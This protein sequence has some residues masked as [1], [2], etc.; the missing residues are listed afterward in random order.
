MPIR[1][2]DRADSGSSRIPEAIQYG[3]K[4]LVT[5][6]VGIDLMEVP[7]CCHY[8]HYQHELIPRRPPRRWE[9]DGIGIHPR[10]CVGIMQEPVD[11]VLTVVPAIAYILE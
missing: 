5:Q 2:H 9:V 3:A 8:M 10:P 6:P 4:C 1:S 11:N 7:A